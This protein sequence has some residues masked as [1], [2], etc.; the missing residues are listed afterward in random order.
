M[1]DACQ[2]PN[3]QTWWWFRCPNC[4]RVP[5]SCGNE[6]QGWTPQQGPMGCSRAQLVAC[7]WM[8]PLEAQWRLL[9]SL[10]VVLE[11]KNP[12]ESWGASRLA[13]LHWGGR[14]ILSKGKV[15][16]FFQTRAFFIA[17]RTTLPDIVL[18]LFLKFSSVY[19][20]YIG[21]IEPPFPSS[22]STD[23]LSI[24]SPISPSCIFPFLTHQVQLQ[25]PECCICVESFTGTW[26]T[27]QWLPMPAH[28]WLSLSH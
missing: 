13:E 8:W 2:L 5:C 17:Q 9:S 4:L 20:M 21:P 18:S 6:E 14:K 28:M 7:A 19:T 25:L 26:T 15:F 1:I 12:L 27:Y 16:F 24:I 23:P 3:S 11:T 10:V 22:S